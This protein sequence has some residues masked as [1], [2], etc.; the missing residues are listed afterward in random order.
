MTL[1]NDPKWPERMIWE[2]TVVEIYC[3]RTQWEQKQY[4]GQINQSKV[5]VRSMQGQ[6]KGIISYSDDL[7]W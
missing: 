5:N 7:I 4:Q 2:K 3:D 6:M 1:I